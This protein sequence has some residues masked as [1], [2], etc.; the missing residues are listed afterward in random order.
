MLEKLEK[1]TVI[2]RIKIGEAERDAGL[3]SV[4]TD[5]AAPADFYPTT[6]FPTEVRIRVAWVPSM[7]RNAHGR[8]C[9]RGRRGD[10][11]AARILRPGP[12]SESRPRV[13]TGL[14]Q[15]SAWNCRQ[16]S[17]TKP[18]SSLELRRLQR[19]AGGIERRAHRQG[20]ARDQGARLPHRRGRGAGGHPR[21]R[22]RGA[23]S[24]GA[25]RLCVSVL[26]GGNA[27]AVHDI[28]RSFF[29]SSPR[30]D[31]KSEDLERRR[32]CHRSSRPQVGAA[33]PPGS[34]SIGVVEEHDPQVL[35]FVVTD[36]LQA[37][38]PHL[39]APRSSL[40]APT[41]ARWRRRLR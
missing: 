19:T 12:R 23:V 26:L 33:I 16:P 7:T 28:E 22:H 18:G 41:A 35:S 14:D 1:S 8:L 27:N 5:G 31:L 6:N 32:S 11:A 2:T 29:G 30:V 15:A 3:E 38:A 25:R 9:G 39:S 4:E 17:A 40:L 13:V 10:R 36:E 37:L 34:R 21:P 24:N 20:D